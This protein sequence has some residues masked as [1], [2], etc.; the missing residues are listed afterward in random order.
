MIITSD[1]I[2]GKDVFD[3]D[4]QILGVVQQLKIDKKKKLIVGI[5]IDQG[6]MRPDLFIGL[7]HIRNFGI[8]SVF[9]SE[10]P[11]PKIKGLEVYDSAGK[12]LGYIKNYEA[13]D[14]NLKSILI[15]KHLLSKTYRLKANTI[16]KIGFSVILKVKKENVH[17]EELI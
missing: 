5:L 3:T 12:K 16:K 7:K 17:M 4:G 10:S 8:D 2:L 14:L 11:K 13:D 15:K 6:F 9:L 1:D